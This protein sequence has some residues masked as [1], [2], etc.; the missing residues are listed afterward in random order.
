MTN[1]RLRIYWYSD[2]YA[3]VD[4]YDSQDALVGEIGTIDYEPLGKA[5]MSH[6]NDMLTRLAS[7]LELKLEVHGDPGV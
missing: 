5:G 6:V 1:L 2:D 4:V 7:A 3:E